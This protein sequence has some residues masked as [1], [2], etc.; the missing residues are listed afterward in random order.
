MTNRHASTWVSESAFGVW[1]LNTRIWIYHV[2]KLS[3]D[4]LEPLIKT[5]ADRY[6]VIL[7]AGCGYGHSLPMLDQRFHPD[8]IIGLDI[9]PKMP[10]WVSD[11]LDKCSSKVETLTSSASSIDLADASVDMIFC[12]QTFHHFVDQQGAADEFFRVLKPGGLLLFA[13]SCKKYIHSLPIRILFRHPMDVQKTDGEYLDLLKNT[14]FEISPES[15]DR[16]YL[17]WSRTDLGLLE[18]L[19]F[20]VAKDKEE[21]LIYLAANR[22]DN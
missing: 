6:P 20:K 1:F 10:E 4:A 2:L 5:R 3:L 17:W 11:K 9:D 22:P 13:E 21:T 12:H 19:G 18:K 16:P 7:D 15:V 8:T 14:G